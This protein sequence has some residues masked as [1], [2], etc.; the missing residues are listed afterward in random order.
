MRQ[1]SLLCLQS[2]SSLILQSFQNVIEKNIVIALFLTML[3]GT[4]GNAGNQV[5]GQSTSTVETYFPHRST[6]KR[7]NI[8]SYLHR[9]CKK[10]VC[11]FPGTETET[12]LV[13]SAKICCASDDARNVPYVGADS[14]HDVCIYRRQHTS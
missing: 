1:V 11:R 8:T 7:T 2:F 3:T 6:A 13:A 5:G 14:V 10:K 12:P 4:A 9:K